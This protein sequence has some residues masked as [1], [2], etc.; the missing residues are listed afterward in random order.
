MRKQARRRLG[1]DIFKPQKPNISIDDDYI[2]T[3]ETTALRSTV[4][5]VA[6]AKATEIQKSKVTTRKLSNTIQLLRNYIKSTP[7]IL[8]ASKVIC[9]N[10]LGK[11]R[12]T[13]EN[14]TFFGQH[15]HR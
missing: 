2:I 1:L 5:S 9:Q 6:R 14:A 10:V 8:Y 12:V 13:H 15:L 4:S 7:L 11:D 3:P